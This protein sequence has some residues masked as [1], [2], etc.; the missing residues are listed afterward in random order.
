MLYSKVMKPLTGSFIGG[1]NGKWSGDGDFQPT[2]GAYEF[3]FTSMKANNEEFAAELMKLYDNELT[4][5]GDPAR[6]SWA[7]V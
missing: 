4:Y 7:A 6:D 2:L 1:N 5:I 3:D